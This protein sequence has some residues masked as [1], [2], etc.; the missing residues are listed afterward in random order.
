MSV[1][2]AEPTSALGKLIL[3]GNPNVGK[4]LLFNLL[5]RRYATVSNYPGTTVEITRSTARIGKVIT[6]ILDTPGANSLL[7]QSEDERVTRE[8]L[9]DCADTAQVFQVGDA[10]NLRRTLLLTLQLIEMGMPLTVCLNMTDEAEAAGI[11]VDTDRLAETLGVEVI[12]I[13]ALRRW[14]VERLRRGDAPPRLST[15][16]LQYTADVEEAIAWIAALLPVDVRGSARSLAIGLLSGDESLAGRLRLKPSTRWSIDR[17]RRDLERATGEP[18]A[19]TINRARLAAADALVAGAISFQPP[20]KPGLR[21]RI[22]AIAMH[23][24]WG[25]PILGGILWLAWLLVGKLGAG[26]LV[27]LTEEGLF[28]GLVN[29]AAIRGM[30]A[31][32]SFPHTHLMTEGILTSAYIT[33]GAVTTAGGVARFFHD[34]L[35]GPYG[36]I[37]MGLTYAIAIVLPVV[38]TFFIFFGLLEDSGYLSRLAVM[39]N[40]IFRRIG[41]NG[42]AVLPMVLGLGCDT[43]ATLT[44]RILETRKEAVIVTLLLALGIPCSAQLGV[45]MAMLGPLPLSATLIWLGVLAFTILLV[46][47][48][49]SKLISGERA[50]FVL[51]IPPVRLPR[52]SNIAIKV[53]ART[54]WYLREAVPLFIAGTLLLYLLD[55]T[56]GLGVLQRAI[57][58]MVVGALQLPAE[59]SNAFLIGFL[60]RDYGA[61]GL[62]VLQRDGQLS[63]VQTIVAL[64]VVTLFIP[65]VA[66][67]L[68]I[69]KERG[70]KMAMAMAGF[71]LIYSFGAGWI[72]RVVL[73]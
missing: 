69:V 17:I 49:S 72:L 15:F 10:K 60:R 64:T 35:V 20:E 22:G 27:D 14:N 24:F 39:L 47:W 5:T 50:E 28:N 73:S 57:A 8:L 33:T 31:V 67:F 65:C 18:L 51:E 25:L 7:P 45:I 52:F 12:P 46:G 2:A 48:L 29:P 19:Y 59:A 34:L 9:L 71:I 66:N 6:E 38:A 16:E 61:A 30:D 3:V 43:M 44:T 41:L 56:G 63:E 37:T 58:P 68:M 23:P 70:L 62:F 13:S 36:V 40:R 55:I 1:P 21:D 11:R 53:L 26:V 54:E 4:S 32:A 42:K